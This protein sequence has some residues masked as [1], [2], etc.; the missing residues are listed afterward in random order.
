MYKILLTKRVLKDLG[1]LDTSI[2]ERIGDKLKVL[3]EDPFTN[4]K[5]LSNTSIGTYR[6]RI[7]DYRVIYDIDQDNIVILR[8]GHRKDI[9]K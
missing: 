3:M 4:I 1:K 8:I 9:Y 5:K 6:I 2:K 7:G